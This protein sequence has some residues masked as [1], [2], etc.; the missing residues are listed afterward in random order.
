[1]TGRLIE[2]ILRIPL[3]TNQGCEH[4]QADLAYI[5]NVLTALGIPGHPH[6]LLSHIATLATLDETVLKERQDAMVSSISNTE[7]PLSMRLL[8]SIEQ[9]FI[10]MRSFG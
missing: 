1:M 3:L 10:A 6:P 8:Q 7:T 9:R 4:V 5:M 2:R